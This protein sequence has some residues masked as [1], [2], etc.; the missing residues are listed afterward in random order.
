M[1]VSVAVA[2]LVCVVVIGLAPQAAADD[3]SL[4]WE[5]TDDNFV[6]KTSSGTWFVKF[7][8]PWC[9]HCKRLAPVWDEAA[10]KMTGKVNFAKMDCTAHTCPGVRG[11]PTLKLYEE[12]RDRVYDGGRNFNDIIGFADRMSGPLLR[13][14][15][16]RSF[17]AFD[18]LPGNKMLYLAGGSDEETDDAVDATAADF[19]PHVYFGIT[20]EPKIFEKYGVSTDRL[21]AVVALKSGDETPPVISDAD[22]EGLT[23]EALSAFV[24]SHHLPLFPE[25]LNDNAHNY[26]KSEKMTVVGVVDPQIKSEARPFL[27]TLKA[28]AEAEVS[29]FRFVWLDGIKWDE[30]VAEFGIDEDAFPQ[31]FVWDAKNQLFYFEDGLRTHDA[32]V[33]FLDRVKAGKVEFNYVQGGISGAISRAASMFNNFALDYP[34]LAGVGLGAFIIFLFGFCFWFLIEGETGIAAAT[35]DGDDGQT[36]D[37]K[38]KKLEKKYQ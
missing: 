23:V 28:V 13:E 20:N 1:A 27:K 18:A 25:L 9:G 14:V 21:P 10:A 38:T 33:D 30:F 17:Q 24:D 37:D 8:A 12:G 16:K 2:A 11:Y 26:M 4:V 3:D 5:L 35:D 36:V 34:I 29:R 32:I 19:I 7:Y 22:G 6:S 15:T 31:T